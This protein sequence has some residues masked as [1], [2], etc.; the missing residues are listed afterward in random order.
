MSD[1]CLLWHSRH[2][3]RD[4]TDVPYKGPLTPSKKRAARPIQ[5]ARCINLGS[6]F[7]ALIATIVFQLVADP[8]ANRESDS[9][10]SSRLLIHTLTGSHLHHSP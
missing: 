4:T 3:G 10:A 1:G 9:N 2:R 8:R 6:I 5:Q 7:A